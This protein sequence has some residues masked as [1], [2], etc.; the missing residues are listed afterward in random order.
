VDKAVGVDGPDGRR[1]VVVAV[2]EPES[3]GVAAQA[4][5]GGEDVGVDGRAGRGDGQ[6]GSVEGG[7]PVA[8]P[9][10][11]HLGQLGQ[12]PRRRLLDAV[13]RPAR[14]GQAEPD[15]DRDGL[16]VVEQ[17][18]R[19]RGPRGQPVAARRAGRGVDPVAEPA[20]RSMSF[21]DRPA[22]DPQ[23]VGELR[24]APPGAALEQAEEPQQPG[25]GRQ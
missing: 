20:E 21:A 15:A 11:Q 19:D 24:P 13:H 18:R 5:Q 14:G 25:R 10:R 23:P 17:Q 6:G 4:R 12:R 7:D 16:V 1:P 3:L 2:V 22:G 8:Q 9:R